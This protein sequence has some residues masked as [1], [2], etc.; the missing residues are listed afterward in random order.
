MEANHGS[1]TRRR[2]TR[3]C[4]A[5]TGLSDSSSAPPLRGRRSGPPLREC[6]HHHRRFV[7][8]GRLRRARRSHGHRA[9]TGRG[10]RAGRG[11]RE[12]FGAAPGRAAS[13][14]C[15]HGDPT[16]GPPARRAR[17]RTAA[18][19]RRDTRAAHRLRGFLHDGLRVADD[20]GKQ[21]GDGLEDDQDRC[22]TSAEHVVAERT[23]RPRASA[24]KHPRRTGRR[25]PRTTQRSASVPLRTLGP[26]LGRTAVRTVG[27]TSR[28]GGTAA[29][30][31]SASS[32]DVQTSGLHD[33]AGAAAVGVSS[34]R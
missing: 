22:F 34:T 24:S 5:R 19:C 28:G 15:W 32:E 21:P 2:R 14:R 9:S 1:G 31:T 27:I 20:A 23:P 12:P 10:D 33:H 26:E 16:A 30:G 25:C 3:T 8:L 7:G 6:A 17:A 13:G 4:K 18:S 29:A 11:A